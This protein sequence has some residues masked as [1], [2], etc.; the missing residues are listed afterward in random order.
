M[1][2]KPTQPPG[3]EKKYIEAKRQAT[4]S[5]LTGTGR[6]LPKEPRPSLAPALGMF[7]A[8]QS[9]LLEIRML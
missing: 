4:L 1:P 6:P 3:A 2:E 5:Q 9:V 8:S 7:P